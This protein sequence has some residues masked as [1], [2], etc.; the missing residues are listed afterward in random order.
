MIRL[1]LHGALLILLTAAACSN[2]VASDTPWFAEAD[3]A[4][5]PRL[6]DGLWA[7]PDDPGCKANTRLPAERWPDCM[8]AWVV[9]GNELFSLNW[10]MEGEGRNRR[11]TSF[12]WDR[13][14]F[15]LVGGEPMILQHNSCPY[16]DEVQPPEGAADDPALLRDPYRF[17]YE[18]LQP[19][20]TGADGRIT[21]YTAWPVLCGPLPEGDGADRAVTDRPFPGLGVVS[22]NCLAESAAAIRNAARAS[23]ALTRD[24]D[25]RRTV[26]WVREGYH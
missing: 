6:R 2:R 1:R 10:T 5:A 8:N 14:E 3:A 11:R 13:T 23:E 15:L 25:W 17:C 24:P 16:A 9:R 21:A 26:R 12:D 22:E 4:A 7:S 20:A 19:E 18:A